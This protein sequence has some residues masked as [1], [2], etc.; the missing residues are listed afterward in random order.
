M[1]VLLL[2]GAGIALPALHIDSRPNAAMVPVRK[3]TLRAE[4]RIAVKVQRTLPSRLPQLRRGFCQPDPRRVL[5]GRSIGR[6]AAAAIGSAAARRPSIPVPA[7]SG[8]ICCQ[9]QEKRFMRGR[10]RYVV[11]GNGCGHGRNA[12]RGGGCGGQTDCRRIERTCALQNARIRAG[13]SRTPKTGGAPRRRPFA[14]RWPPLPSRTQPI[15]AIGLTGQM[16]GAVLLDENGAV[17]RPALIWCDTRTQPAV[18]LAHGEDRL[19]AA[20]RAHLQPGAAQLYRDQAAVGQGA[21]AGDLRQDSPHPLPQGLRALPADGRVRHRRAG[22]FGDAAA[23]RDPSPLVAGSGRGGG[24]SR[25]LAA[26]SL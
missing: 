1:C 18:R 4:S 23:G 6:F 15:A 10:A 3:V 14:G 21:P 11:P 22:G 26:Q 12:G 24:D 13:R 19:R 2:A 20:D 5:P 8:V 17:L 16:H 7:A 25:E 9:R